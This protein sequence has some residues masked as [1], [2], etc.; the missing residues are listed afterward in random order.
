V[1][2][3]E[4]RAAD[5]AAEILNKKEQ[6]SRASIAFNASK[7]ANEQKEKQRGFL[8]ELYQTATAA[9]NCVESAITTS[10]V[11]GAS[12]S[13]LWAIDLAATAVNTLEHILS[14][15]ERVWAEA[16]R[17]DVPRSRP[18]RNSF[19][20]MQSSAKTYFPDDAALLQP[21]FQKMG[22]PTAGF[23]K[24]GRPGGGDVKV[25]GWFPV[26]GSFFGGLTL[27]F[28]MALVIVEMFGHPVPPT[29]RFLVV[30]VLA[31]GAA[32]SGSFLGGN[33]AARGQIP[34]PFVKD[35]P[36]AFTA[37]GGIAIFIIFFLIG[38]YG[39]IRPAQSGATATL[40]DSRSVSEFV[41]KG[42]DVYTTA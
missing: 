10:E 39:Y 8:A 31:F 12:R 2:S 15:Y 13:E 36:I 5:A 23:K 40:I 6:Y 14:F 22:L 9:F 3:N 19:Y 25:P 17:L 35:H 26:V 29:G 41:E 28:F 37:T 34:I 7:A 30:S 42:A 20:A 32:L 24:P 1:T 27:L 33:A 21:E 11:L 38:Y 18:N 16:D 4:Q